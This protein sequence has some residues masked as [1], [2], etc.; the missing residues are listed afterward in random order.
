MNEQFDPIS[1]NF[2]ELISFNTKHKKSRACQWNVFR[3][4]WTIYQNEIVVDK[5]G[6]VIYLR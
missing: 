3:F 5:F 6:N 2:Y 4:E 1:F